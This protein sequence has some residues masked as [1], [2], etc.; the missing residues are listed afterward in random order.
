MGQVKRISQ[1][2]VIPDDIT[3]IVRALNPSY[4]SLHLSLIFKMAVKV[5]LII[6]THQ[7]YQE[8]RIFLLNSWKV[9]QM[10]RTKVQIQKILT[11]SLRE[12]VTILSQQIQ[13]QPYPA[14]WLRWHKIL[15]GRVSEIPDGNLSNRNAN[16]SKQL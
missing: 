13:V 10:L 4:L 7:Q 14:S 3:F 6:R 11:F 9:T 2:K 15:G 5:A 8:N 1:I 16:Y 12:V